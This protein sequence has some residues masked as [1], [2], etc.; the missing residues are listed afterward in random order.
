[1]TTKTMGTPTTF[2][3]YRDTLEEYCQRGDHQF[4]QFLLETGR[5][6]VIDE[7]I[8]DNLVKKNLVKDERGDM[9]ET[10]GISPDKPQVGIVCQHCRRTA[11]ADANYC[12]YCA[13][14]ITHVP[15]PTI[16]PMRVPLNVL[17]KYREMDPRFCEFLEETGRIIAVD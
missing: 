3:V 17:E 5:I 13:L 2:P 14:P 8:R 6:K 4:V 7:Q 10:P 11:P 12:P 15:D 1:M 9:P 16:T